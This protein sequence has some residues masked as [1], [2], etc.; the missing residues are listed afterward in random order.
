M[1][2]SNACYHGVFD[3]RSRPERMLSNH[4]WELRS[5]R[6]AFSVVVVSVAFAVAVKVGRT[7]VARRGVGLYPSGHD[8]RGNEKPEPAVGRSLHGENRD[9]IG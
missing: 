6:T 3:P 9:P 1:H 5:V 4:R 8:S 2:D 7:I